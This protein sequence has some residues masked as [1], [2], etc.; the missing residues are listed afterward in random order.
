M[1]RLDYGVVFRSLR[2]PN[3]AGLP[4]PILPIINNEKKKYAI[5][6]G[7]NMNVQNLV[8]KSTFFFCEKV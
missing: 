8:L 3:F 2:C 7:K 6:K 5:N 4:P 1:L